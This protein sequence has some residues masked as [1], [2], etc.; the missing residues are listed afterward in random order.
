VIHSFILPPPPLCVGVRRDG[1]FPERK[2]INVSARLETVR[3]D[4][5]LVKIGECWSCTGIDMKEMKMMR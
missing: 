3:L 4:G 2:I 1:Y 5:F